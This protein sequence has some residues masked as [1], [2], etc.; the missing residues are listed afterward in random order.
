MCLLAAAAAV[1]QWWF[2]ESHRVALS[3]P[4]HLL[5]VL[6]VCFLH[7]LRTV[8]KQQ[9]KSPA[10]WIGWAVGIAV[11][12]AVLAWLSLWH[13][14]SGLLP[15]GGLMAVLC[16]VYLTFYTVEPG[17]TR[18]ASMLLFLCA[19]SSAA[20]SVA[21]LPSFIQWACYFILLGGGLLLYQ[22]GALRAVRFHFPEEVFCGLVMA[23]GCGVATH[24]WM[25]H[26]H[27]WLCA[28]ALLLW[29][30]VVMTFNSLRLVS[31]PPEMI[32]TSPEWQMRE[33]RRRLVA[34]VLLVSGVLRL[35]GWFGPLSAE[36]VD[37]QIG[38]MI[39]V[40]GLLALH[41]LLQKREPST[42]QAAALLALVTPA[43]VAWISGQVWR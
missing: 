36:R 13:L 26:G 33:T 31:A 27:S 41:R 10:V 8:L 1:W 17:S 40:I 35:A 25:D 32:S 16:V 11:L 18:H 3:W 24:F 2:A 20:V 6:A 29:G 12:V 21:P 14:P 22:P 4:Y 43:G 7:V 9:P 19:A 37:Y 23:L 42:R 15:S 34:L 30:V 38:V 39:T 5:I 28:E